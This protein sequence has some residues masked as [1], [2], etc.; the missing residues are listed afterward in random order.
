LNA[1][2]ALH[3]FAH[4]I[5][6]NAIDQELR[7][8]EMRR[9][10]GGVFPKQP[11]RA[12]CIGRGG[13]GGDVRAAATIG[14]RDDKATVNE[15]HGA[16]GGG[17]K[18]PFSRGHR[19]GTPQNESGKQRQEHAPHYLPCDCSHAKSAPIPPTPSMAPNAR[20]TANPPFI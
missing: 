12:R 20:S 17:G 5:G 3:A 7:P 16:I 8:I 13:V 14:T 4:E 1:A 11:H 19:Y 15:L 9:I 6:G 18:Y 10:G 2:I